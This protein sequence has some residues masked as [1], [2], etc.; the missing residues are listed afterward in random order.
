[1]V[2]FDV[3]I[4][5]AVLGFALAADA[6]D[7]LGDGTVTAGTT[8]VISSISFGGECASLVRIGDRVIA[9]GGELCG[10]PLPHTNLTI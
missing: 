7:T 1:M 2:R 5:S 9:V 3:F 6:A 4:C 10:A 8:A